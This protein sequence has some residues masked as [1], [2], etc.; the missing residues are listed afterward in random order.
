MY[1]VPRYS[2]FQSQRIIFFSD[3]YL[4]DSG[5]HDVLEVGV[6]SEERAVDGDDDVLVVGHLLQ[7]R[8][9]PRGR[10]E[11]RTPGY[12]LAHVPAI[13]S[14]LNYYMTNVDKIAQNTKNVK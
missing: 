4:A 3:Y 8:R 6:V 13:S 11:R 9:D 10:H 14:Y 7:Q 2:S 5:L 1:S 12:N